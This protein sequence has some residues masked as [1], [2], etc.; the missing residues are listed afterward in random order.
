MFKQG[1]VFF[2]SEIDSDH[3]Y[4]FENLEVIKL[5]EEKYKVISSAYIPDK[6][7]VAF[8]LMKEN[9]NNSFKDEWKIVFF[10]KVMKMPEMNGGTITLD[11]LDDLKSNGSVYEIY[12]ELDGSFEEV[13][14][15]S[16]DLISKHRSSYTKEVNQSSIEND[17][18]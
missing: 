3:L 9:Q 12:K 13:L 1:P 14:K 15:I 7:D 2:T 16:C 6:Y 11:N 8:V 18:N 17:Y 10:K 5:L 4:P